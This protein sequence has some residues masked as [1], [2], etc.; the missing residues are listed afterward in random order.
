MLP[1]LAESGLRVIALVRKPEDPPDEIVLDLLAHPTASSGPDTAA[2]AFE[3]TSIRPE[4][5]WPISG[6]TAS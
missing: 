1:R 4:T 2:R 5:R 6:P 3:L